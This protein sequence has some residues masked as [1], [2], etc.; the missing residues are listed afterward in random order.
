MRAEGIEERTY[1]HSREFLFGSTP[2]ENYKRNL[3]FDPNARV[4]KRPSVEP[5][6]TPVVSEGYSSY[7]SAYQ[8]SVNRP[9]IAEK[10]ADRLKFL[11][12]ARTNITTKAMRAPPKRPKRLELL[13]R[14]KR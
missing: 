7:T 12:I 5:V 4:N 14:L 1:E 2:A 9:S 8:S 6:Q 11:P 13:E 3:I 10:I